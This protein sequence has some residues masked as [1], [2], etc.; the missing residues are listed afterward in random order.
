MV[1]H[2]PGPWFDEVLAGL[3]AQDYP[4][5]KLLVLVDGDAGDLPARI[6]AVVPKPF[7]RGVVANGFGSAANEVLRLVEGQNGFFCFMHDDVAL[8]P[9]AIRLL[10][11][12][13]YRSN[14]GIVGPKLV[15]WLDPTILQHVGYG[16]DRF[17]EI[18]P[19]VEPGET[20]QEQHDAV[21]D[22][23]ALPSA[24]MLVRADLFRSLGGFSPDISYYG[25]DVDLCWRAHHQGARVLVVPS[26]KARHVEALEQRRPDL[27]HELLRARHRLRTVATLTGGRRLPLLSLQLTLIT[28]VQFLLGLFTG[29]AVRAVAGLRALIGLIPRTPRIIARRRTV[30][31]GRLVPEREVVGLQVRGSSRIAAYLRSRDARPDA[32]RSGGRAWR[33]RA[34]VSAAIGWLVLVIAVVVGG[35]SLIT[36]GVPPFGEF[37]PFD[38]SPMDMLRAY[39]T[40][41]NPHGLGEASASPTGVALVALGSAM[42]LFRMG[43]FHTMS[44]VGLIVVGAAGTWR[45]SSAFSTNRSR[46]ASTLM[47]AAV[48]LP[49]QLI[50]MGRWG[51]LACYAALP[52]SLDAM[53]LFAGLG[54]GPKDEVGE[55]TIGFGARRHVQLLSAGVLV[56]AI[57][58]AFEPTYL[59]VLAVVT[60]AISVATLLTGASW[61]T[62]W[63]LLISGLLAAIGACVLNAPWLATV[64]GD[65]GWS[66][67]VGPAPVADRGYT[68]VELAS[69]DVGNARGVIL[70]LALYVPVVVALLIG[71]GWRF[72]WAA[73]SAFLVVTFGWLA[74][75]DDS[76]SFLFRLPEPGILLA[77]VA[78]GLALSAGCTVASFELDVRGGSFGWR[79]PLSIIG[80]AALA[81]GVLPGV[82]ALGT[83]RW[84]VPRT[85][86]VDLL[87]QLGEQ[88]ADGDYRVLWVGDPR[89]LP[90]A[91]LEHRAGTAYAITEERQLDISDAWAMPPG[92]GH[93]QIDG[94]LL[95]IA[96]GSTTRAGRLLAPLS[97]RFVIVPLIDGAQSTAENPLPVPGGL[98]DALGDQ[99]D[100]AEVFSPPNFVVFENR[101]WIP[102]RSVLTPEGADASRE[103][104]AA[105]LAQADLSGAAPIMI[106]AEPYDV[107][108]AEVPA[109]T[110]HVAVPRADGWDFAVDGEV[111]AARPAFG[112]TIA[113][114]VPAA[115]S[116]TLTYRTSSWFRI[117]LLA[118]ALAW[119]LVLL[120][121]SN[122]R[123][124]RARP[125]QRIVLVADPGPVVTLDPILAAQDDTLRDLRRPDG[126]EMADAPLVIADPA[127]TDPVG[128]GP[129]EPGSVEAG[130]AEPGPVEPGPVEHPRVES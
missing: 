7:V 6:A 106:G 108:V 64:F 97:I 98:L 25:E 81:V 62:P 99:L 84:D 31:G 69:F 57:A 112:T 1:A 59:F 70:A 127:D 128:A 8:E 26:A 72:G 10:V 44:I 125:R 123:L 79:Q 89:V 110:V 52:W 13:T 74:V 67:A 23:F 85:T 66:A 45:L 3:A 50:S 86:M 113:F 32:T 53:R 111:I 94:A 61:Y 130:P 20:D 37:L 42:T 107:S 49:A 93:D 88:P 82:F 90:A 80:V 19:L 91:G 28:V 115:G 11:E 34:G 21:R 40:G 92:P 104:G 2:Q 65:G 39:T 15:D 27:H 38:D 124:G 48:P 63:R 105:V 119:L 76:S 43:L 122:A 109:G 29:Q 16:V 71:R 18:D 95:A 101:A 116:A 68:L 5:L 22:V 46:L 118:Q 30:A 126:D 100:L 17:G 4:N 87:G 102:I 60:L 96:R 58:T 56:A 41:W 73:R 121:A 117:T 47:Y 33:E 35:R 9:D 129:A 114:D 54:P 12:E 24:C 78:L 83:G 103:A 120:L 36:G 55:R 51:A 14:A 77:P 75:L